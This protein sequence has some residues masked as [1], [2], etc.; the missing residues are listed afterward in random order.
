MLLQVNKKIIQHVGLNYYLM[1][2][3]K[4]WLKKKIGNFLFNKE[5]SKYKASATSCYIFVSIHSHPH[6]KPILQ[7]ETVLVTPN[8]NPCCAAW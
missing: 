8:K 4:C 1:L 5:D 2:V 7:D 3:E 6:D